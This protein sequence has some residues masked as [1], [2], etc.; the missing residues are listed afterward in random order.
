MEVGGVP[1]HQSS[2]MGGPFK[3]EF[4]KEEDTTDERSTTTSNSSDTLHMSN[5]TEVRAY[6]I[7]NQVSHT[8]HSY[9]LLRPLHAL[10]GRW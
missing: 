10:P 6:P 4:Y 7:P 1:Q 9:F 5:V 8:P 3:V 2:S